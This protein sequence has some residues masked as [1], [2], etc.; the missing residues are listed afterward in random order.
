MAAADAI[1]NFQELTTGDFV[2][3]EVLHD[4]I[5]KP[6]RIA[7]SALQPWGMDELSAR[8]VFDSNLDRIAAVAQKLANTTPVG[9]T[10]KLASYDF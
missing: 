5:W 3:F 8:Q 1:R 6:A 9:E 4:G 7:Y 2:N 10:I